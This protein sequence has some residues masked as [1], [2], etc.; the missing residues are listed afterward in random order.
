MLTDET[1]GHLR[2][3][4]QSKDTAKTIEDKTKA[5]TNLET[6]RYCSCN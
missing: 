6:K 4:H 3:Q 1:S 2:K 5:M